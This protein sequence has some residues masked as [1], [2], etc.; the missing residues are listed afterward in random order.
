MKDTEQAALSLLEGAPAILRALLA[1]LPDSILTAD[2][3]RGWSPKRLL[4]HEVDVERTFAERLH[5]MIDEDNPAI[6]SVDPMTTIDDLQSRP[7]SDLLDE[8]QTQRTETVAWLR[9]LTDAQLQRI[10]QHDTL[11]QFTV[12][13]L[14]HYWP[15]HDLAH[16]AG[17]RRM[18]VSVLR[19]EVGGIEEFDI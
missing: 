12:S 13:Q 6:I 5:R 11:G 9:T 8:L 17:I 18:L 3:D 14:I 4:T 7:T 19:H 2:L 16:I 10:A 1:G 15:T